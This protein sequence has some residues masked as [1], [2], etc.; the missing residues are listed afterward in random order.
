MYIYLWF[1]LSYVIFCFLLNDP[2]NVLFLFIT[3]IR[4]WKIINKV[5]PP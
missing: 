5:N 1:K 2:E 4:L 3:Q